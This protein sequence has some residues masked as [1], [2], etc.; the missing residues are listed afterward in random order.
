MNERELEAAA[1]QLIEQERYSDVEDLLRGVHDEAIRNNQVDLA[2]CALQELIHIY[3]IQRLSDHERCQLKIEKLE[4]SAWSFVSSSW[5]Y[6]YSKK[7]FEAA[8]A[9]ADQAI[10]MAQAEGDTSASYT[11]RA[12]RG[13]A[14]I[15][16][17]RP[18]EA[19]AVLTEMLGMV[20][21]RMKLVPGDELGFLE[22]AYSKGVAR[23]TVA[24]ILKIVRPFYREQGFIDRGAELAEK[25]GI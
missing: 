10:V 9:K 23:G 1:A 12:A 15:N 25:L 3:V 7:D 4:N 5:F 17:E 18:A 11:A 16:L 8:I 14:L 22:L 21:Q 2:I 13:Q 6:L 20:S 19:K 24:E